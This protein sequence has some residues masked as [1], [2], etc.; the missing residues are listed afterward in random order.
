MGLSVKDL[1]KI[2]IFAALTAVGAFL[3]IP[4]GPV[5]ITLQSMFVLLAGFVL[6]V[7]G[8]ILSQV[9]YLLIGL[10]G[11]PVFSNF[12][13][14]I[15]SILLPS[16]GFLL[17]FLPVAGISGLAYK[18]ANT[19]VGFLIYGLFAT[20]LLYI[21][22]LSYMIFILNFIMKSGLPFSTIFKIGLLAFVPG[23]LLKLFTASFI[24]LR[25]KKV[26]FF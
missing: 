10:I 25:L 7:K 23:D 20:V 17:G 8:A 15:Q 26:N 21:I 16:F 2:S 22:G 9:I 4:I 18:K 13:G 12:T 5:P 6:G 11:L 19:I 3:S 14:G 24:G 1:S